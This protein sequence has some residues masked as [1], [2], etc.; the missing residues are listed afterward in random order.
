[1]TNQ[2]RSLVQDLADFVVEA[3]YED[4]PPEV[5]HS[6]KRVLLDS[7][8]C[9]LDAAASERGRIASELARRLGGPPEA[10]I[11]GTR[12]KVSCANAAFAHGESTYGMN[13]DCVMPL[14]PHISPVVLPAALAVGESRSVSGKELIL[15]M[16]LGVELA[17]RVA[18]GQVR[19]PL[20][21]SE[22][23]KRGKLDFSGVRG[24]SPYVF[25]SVAGAGKLMGLDSARIASAMGIAAYNVPI[26]ARNH[27]NSS[28]I[29]ADAAS[30]TMRAF[31]PGWMAHVA[32]TSVLLAELGFNGNITVLDTETGYWACFGADGWRPEA[33]TGGLG[34]EWHLPGMRF[35]L[36]SSC[37]IMHSSL[38]ALVHIIDEN[39]LAPEEIEQIKAWVHPHFFSPLRVNRNP[40]NEV[41]AQFSVAYLY[42]LA[43]YHIPPGV[44]WR[45]RA[46]M[47]S[48]K[49]REFMKKVSF[50]PY[51]YNVQE[52]AKA[53]KL[54]MCK[55]DVT[56]RGRVYH[57]ERTFRM[58]AP[59]PAEARMSN[60][61]LAEKFRQ[62]A[63]AILAPDKA[64]EVIKSVWDLENLRDLRSLMEKLHN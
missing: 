28:R 43:A 48:P 47:T 62:N 25:G 57:E 30:C 49:L 2:P 38:D 54:D 31:S 3:K 18:G 7:L 6:A 26:P 10:S 5:V 19:R 39:K 14:E 15:A 56:A 45:S 60:D 32:V 27:W 63:R 36:Y 17:Y 42:A 50:V 29:G 35:K 55:I 52:M 22:G 34:R 11:I 41:E 44:E 1:M 20:V 13:F 33:V 53:D 24:D 21:V 9:I 37:G 4:L 12:D 16:A 61:A 58:G 59:K 64:N 51:D 46:N 23:P 8:G 40:S